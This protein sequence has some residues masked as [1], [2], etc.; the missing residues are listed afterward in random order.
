MEPRHLRYFQAVAESKGFRE[1]SRRQHVVQP[2]LSQAV[3]DLARIRR[4]I[5]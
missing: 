4:P 5:F 3:A 1:A 2:A